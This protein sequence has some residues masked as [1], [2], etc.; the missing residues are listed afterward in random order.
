MS[1]QRCLCLDVNSDVA[2]IDRPCRRASNYNGHSRYK[3]EGFQNSPWTLVNFH[4]KAQKTQNLKNCHNDE[5]NMPVFLRAAALL[6][7]LLQLSTAT[8]HSS[9]RTSSLDTEN[10]RQLRPQTKDCTV[11]VTA[12]ASLFHAETHEE[13]EDF[14]CEIDPADNDGQA[15]HV[16]PIKGSTAQMKELKKLLANGDLVSSFAENNLSFHSCCTSLF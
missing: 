15:K 4:K 2:L 10:H 8:K 9:L 16:L 7:A 6:V 14:L 12:D 1:L 5:I 13:L 11:M 3:R